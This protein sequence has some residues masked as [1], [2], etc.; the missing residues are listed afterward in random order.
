MADTSSISAQQVQ[1]E[2]AELERDLSLR[3]LLWES[4]DEW[5]KLLDEWKATPFQTLNI[6]A[7]QKNVNR[8]TQSIFMLDRGL[9]ANDIVPK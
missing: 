2:L 8:F 6:D 3:R 9:P 5:T 4:Q 7:L 1:A